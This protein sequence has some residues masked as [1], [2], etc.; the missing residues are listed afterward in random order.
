MLWHRRRVFLAVLGCLRAF[1]I[2]VGVGQGVGNRGLSTGRQRRPVGR[3]SG[4]PCPDRG[5]GRR[6]PVAVR[7]PGRP[8]DRP[9]LCDPRPQGTAPRQRWAEPLQN[10]RS[11]LK[12]VSEVHQFKNRYTGRMSF[13]ILRTAKLTTWG[14]PIKP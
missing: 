3:V 11:E 5:A 10:R 12:E 1:L 13:Q 7:R 2:R 9:L 14:R 6:P 4:C 8:K